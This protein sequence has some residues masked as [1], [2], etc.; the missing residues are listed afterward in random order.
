MPGLF[1]FDEAGE[2][3]SEREKVSSIGLEC[4]IESV[5]STDLAGVLKGLESDILFDSAGG[6]MGAGCEMKRG[7]S[8]AL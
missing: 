8:W 3:A 1:F 2:G 4:L 7:K 6:L 5:A